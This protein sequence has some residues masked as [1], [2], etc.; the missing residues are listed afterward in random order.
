VMESSRELSLK[1]FGRRIHFYAPG[2]AHF[3][4]P[5]FSS[6]PEIFASISVTGAACALSCEHCRGRILE[7]MIPATTPARLIEVCEGLR[8][9]GCVGLLVSGGC[10]PDGS[11][12]LEK[13]TDAIARVKRDLGLRVVVHTGLVSHQTAR[14]LGEAGV[15]AALIDVIGS[16]ETIQEVYHLNATVKDYERALEALWESGV[17]LVPH[18]LVGLDRGRLRG[19]LRAL[20]MISGQGPSA[21]VVIALTPIRGTP[22][23]A[24]EPPTPEDILR[25]L[26]AARLMMPATPLAL[27]CVRPKRGHRAETDALAVRAGVN[28]IAFP[29]EG[30]VRLAESMGLSTAF[31]PLCCSQVFKD[32]QT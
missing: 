22:M 28:A 31:S 27:G 12:P 20:R 1:H 10:L 25:V 32:A 29:T 30:A 17:P 3:K 19:E 8:S 16:D 7:S 18:V 15:D 5:R 2:F 13:F 24:V 4:S 26:L 23:E 6:S 9:R 14:G 21:V 11:V